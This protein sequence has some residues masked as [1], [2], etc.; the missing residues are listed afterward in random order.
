MYLCSSLQKHDV[1]HVIRT[2]AN[3]GKKVQKMIYSLKVRH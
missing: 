1:T 2:R 3:S